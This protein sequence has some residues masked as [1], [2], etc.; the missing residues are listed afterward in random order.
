MKRMVMGALCAALLVMLCATAEAAGGHTLA[1]VRES[2][3]DYWDTGI[4]VNGEAVLAP[5]YVPDAEAMPV[6]RMR[7]GELT[8]EEVAE[9][10]GVEPE[11]ECSEGVIYLQYYADGIDFWKY[12]NRGFYYQAHVSEVWQKEWHPVFARIHTDKRVWADGVTPSP[13]TT[14]AENQSYSLEEAIALM[15][16]K[17]DALYAGRG[18]LFVQNV[19]ITSPIV[20]CK[21]YDYSTEPYPLGEWLTGKGFYRV[22]GAQT[23]RGIPVFRGITQAYQGLYATVHTELTDYCSYATPDAGFYF[24]DEGHWAINGLFYEEVEA[25]ADDVPL[26]TFEEAVQ[27]L[28][29]VFE[30]GRVKNVY[31]MK[32]GFVICADPELT[33]PS[34]RKNGWTE[35][36]WR[37]VPMWIC[38]CSYV[39]DPNREY[40]SSEREEPDANDPRGA[41]WHHS[42][43][44]VNAQTGEYLDTMYT[45]ADRVYA[46]ELVT[47]D[48]VK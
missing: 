38:D 25:L 14:Y 22:D 28:S 5:V 23:L 2:A 45:G 33:Y 21:G 11:D 29:P 41:D 18:S 42:Y 15:Q 32:L 26:C 4:V 30:S 40:P 17:F 10:F 47:W 35:A 16:E 13:A 24:V 9:A 44:M 48:D 34:H 6:L 7:R 36:V 8:K 19:W 37:V 12:D 20:Y 31:D 46:P 27:A 1:E 43:L 3:P 39:K